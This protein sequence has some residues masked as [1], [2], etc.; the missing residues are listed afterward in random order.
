[1]N[2]ITISPNLRVRSTVAV[3]YSASEWKLNTREFPRTII[4]KV[5][6]SLNS[7]INQDF[8]SGFSRDVIRSN[9]R[10]LTKQFALYGADTKEVHE[11]LDHIMYSVYP[12]G[13]NKLTQNVVEFRH[14]V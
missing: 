8:N 4:E 6:N 12:S 10:M 14:K 1:M 13:I 3:N 11:I 9:F 5:A 2:V 7:R